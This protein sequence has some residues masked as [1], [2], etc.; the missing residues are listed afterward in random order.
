MGPLNHEI[1]LIRMAEVTQKMRQATSRQNDRQTAASSAPPRA[2]PLNDYVIGF[3]MA[4]WWRSGGR[5]RRCTEPTG[6]GGDVRNVVP[7]VLEDFR[8]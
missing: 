7:V 3:L 6:L 1:I 4:T 8:P 2:A 5:G